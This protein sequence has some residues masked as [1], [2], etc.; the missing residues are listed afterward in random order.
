M[1]RPG[2]R[3]SLVLV[4][5]RFISD[6]DNLTSSTTVMASRKARESRYNDAGNIGRS[7]FPHHLLLKQFHSELDLHRLTGVRMPT[8]VA[9]DEDGTEDVDAFFASPSTSAVKG[10]KAAA[11]K[12][13]GASSVKRKGGTNDARRGGPRPDVNHELGQ[14]GRCV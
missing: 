12:G 6:L 1:K 2:P 11:G 7:V 9:R 10:G 3:S 14:R 5:D 4:V 8:N 13:G